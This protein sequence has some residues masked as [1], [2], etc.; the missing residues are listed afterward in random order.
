MGAREIGVNGAPS[1][2]RLA[3]ETN[4]VQCPSYERTVQVPI[5][6]PRERILEAGLCGEECHYFRRT[7]TNANEQDEGSGYRIKNNEKRSSELT[8][9]VSNMRLVVGANNNA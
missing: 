3:E 2:F 1:L 4:T 9:F 6:V 7:P 5:D 8:R